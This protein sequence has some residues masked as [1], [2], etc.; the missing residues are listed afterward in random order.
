MEREKQLVY[1]AHNFDIKH[2]RNER[3][4]IRE[5]DREGGG[6]GGGRE[7]RMEENKRGEFSEQE[8]K[9]VNL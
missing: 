4:C 6:G 9:T 2:A 1:E 7:G 3:Y 8:R 5:R